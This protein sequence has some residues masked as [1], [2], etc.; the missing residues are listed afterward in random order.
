MD[1]Y[2]T[3]AHDKDSNANTDE[4][5]NHNAETR[6]ASFVSTVNEHSNTHLTISTN[7]PDDVD[8]A[9][10]DDD[11]VETNLKQSAVACISTSNNDDDDNNAVWQLLRQNGTMRE[12][13]LLRRNNR[14]VL[15]RLAYAQLMGMHITH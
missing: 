11:N 10:V 8:D 14:Q 2:S 7:C 13:D 1:H 3:T 12:N 5:K 9:N 15:H 6:S 4:R